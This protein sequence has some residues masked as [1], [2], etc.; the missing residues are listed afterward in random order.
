MSGAKYIAS[1]PR[2]TKHY[3]PGWHRVV[4]GRR[5]HPK[6][7]RPLSLSRLAFCRDGECVLPYVFA[8]SA[9]A[10]YVD[11]AEEV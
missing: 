4:Q 1:M 3:I 7:E 5:P 8:R 9:S 10:L 11:G 6:V 2:R